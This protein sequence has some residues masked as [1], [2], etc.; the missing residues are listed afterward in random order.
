VHVSPDEPDAVEARITSY[1][2]AATA[3]PV[4]RFRS[5]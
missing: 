3:L 4:E 2:A 1:A 5:P